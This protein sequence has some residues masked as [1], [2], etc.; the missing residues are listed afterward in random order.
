M[1]EKRLERKSN[2]KKAPGE[3]IFHILSIISEHL[4]QN[5][6]SN[7]TGATSGAETD[8]PSGA[9]EFIPGF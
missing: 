6:S 8:Y 5:N 9:C 1:Y 4:K 3:L 7:K 2:P